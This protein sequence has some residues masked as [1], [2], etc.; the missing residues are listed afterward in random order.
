MPKKT[1]FLIRH[2]KA[3]VF[4]FLSNDF[5]RN[6]LEKGRERAV[7][8]ASSLKAE[9]NLDLHTH[10]ISSSAN[11]A[12]QTAA[13]FCDSIGIAPAEITYS[14]KIYEAHHLDILKLVNMISD[15][16]DNLFVFG[17]NPGLSAL[18]NYLCDSDID[19]KTSHVAI[20]SLPEDFTFQNLSGGTAQLKGIIS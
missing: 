14:K 20:I 9:V 8:I 11:R 7:R 15:D 1:L 18:T 3:E 10:V 12:Q 19:L 17:H 13:V 16:V 2:A 5:T 4:S 6:I